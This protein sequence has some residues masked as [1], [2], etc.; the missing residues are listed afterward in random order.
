M[1]KTTVIHLPIQAAFTYLA[2][3][4]TPG[5]DHKVEGGGV[6]AGGLGFCNQGQEQKG[7]LGGWQVLKLGSD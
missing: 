7:V 6:H 3:L 2:R 4:L 1:H 5:G